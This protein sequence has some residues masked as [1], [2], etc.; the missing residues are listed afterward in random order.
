[1]SIATLKR[2]TAQKYNTMSVGYQQFSL[3]GGYRNQGY[4]GQ[5]T[6]SRSLPKT[7]MRGDTERGYGGCCG[8][9]RVTPIV[10]SAVT[11]TED[12]RVIKS[13]VLDYDGMIATQYRW[14]RRPQPFTSVKPDSNHN[15]NDQGEYI[16]RLKRDEI[17]QMQMCNK[18]SAPT[19]AA[20]K[21]CVPPHPTPLIFKNR[22]NTPQNFGN[23]YSNSVVKSPKVLGAI[24]QESYLWELNGACIN[25]DIEFQDLGN[26]TSNQNTPFACGIQRD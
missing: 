12:N 22:L 7:M 6:Q 24:S 8:T 25:A 23:P 4:V 15:N 5:S 21:C 11:S 17:R 1:M 13:S 9:Y 26:Q 16:I 10:Q 14:I 18:P 3:N 2:K 19:L 20:A